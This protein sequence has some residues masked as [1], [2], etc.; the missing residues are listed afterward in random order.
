M[1][2]TLKIEVRSQERVIFIAR[3]VYVS[4]RISLLVVEPKIVLNTK[5]FLCLIK[6][7]NFIV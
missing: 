1:V 7:V 2:S 6:L 3:F 4:D 5:S